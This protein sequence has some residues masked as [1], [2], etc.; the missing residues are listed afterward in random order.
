MSRGLG[1]VYKRQSLTISATVFAASGFSAALAPSKPIERATR[2]SFSRA[3]FSAT[4]WSAGAAKGFSS[5]ARTS[6]SP[7]WL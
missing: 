1:D 2:P 5:I 7:S 6:I 4:A 3:L